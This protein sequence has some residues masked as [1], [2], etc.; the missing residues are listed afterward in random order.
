MKHKNLEILREHHINVPSF[1]VVDRK[2]ELDLS[3]SKE[4]L[5]AIRSSFEVEDDDESSFAGQF[6]TFLNVER[7]NVFSYVDKVKESYK[8]LNITNT[9]SKVIVQE[10]IQSDYSGVIFTANPTGILNEMVIVAGEGLGCNIVEDKIAA[11]TYYY[12]VDDKNYYFENETILNQTILNDLIKAAVKIKE[13]FQ[14]D[15]D[16]EYAVK[17]DNIYIL[18][19]RPI[20]TL[21][22]SKTIILDNSNI[23]ES[24]PGISLPLTQ[25]FAKQVYADVFKHCIYHL[26][27]KDKNLVN[28]MS[29]HLDNMLACTNGRIYYNINNWYLII[30]LLPCSEKLI[31]IWQEM[32]GVENKYVNDEKM[33]VTLLTKIKIVISFL[34]Y[35]QS[36]PK[37][38]KK[39]NRKFED[40]FMIF[41]E[42]VKAQ[43]SITDLLATYRAIEKAISSD[44]Y[45]TLINDMYTFIYTG[46]LSKKEKEKL[47]DIKNLE[48]MKPVV[49]L[50]TL[51]RVYKEEK[52]SNRFHQLFQEYIELYGDRCL[53]ELKLETQTYR[54]NPDLLLEYIQ[55]HDETCL[56]QSSTDI[57]V[58][59]K[60]K[61]AKLGIYNREISRL[62]RTRIF[63]L[64]R[65]IFLKIGEILVKE[66][67][68][69]KREDI[70]YLFLE[71]INEKDCYTELVNKRKIQYKKNETIP[72]YSRLVYA[73]QIVE[74]HF[75]NINMLNNHD[76]L[77]GTGSSLG[78]VEGEV[79]VVK[80]ADSNID[81]KNKIIVA[82][83]TDPGWVF[84]IKDAKGI[85]V[86]RGSILS[87]TAIITRELKKPSIVNVK[88]ATSLLKNGDYVQV[89]AYKGIVRRIDGA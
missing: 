16:I 36:T 74:K 10:M 66:E 82:E 83:S 9:A 61:K 39:L 11:T 69:E 62:N 85:I 33:P 26:S 56:D 28:S 80:D 79:V 71:E 21:K 24:Y 31:K 58:N 64:A 48:S 57:K 3:F 45:I 18:Q 37:S 70:F 35:L 40:D 27:Q 14:K 32:L 73:D 19:A 78:I 7:K 25:S 44:W 63:G 50:N 13:I 5:F 75:E 89:D 84:L 41:K 15:M 1:I 51:I 65:S 43:N 60:L 2:E 29:D 76:N 68:I 72:A 88:N 77:F 22:Y 47:N 54:V 4:E 86:E 52:K 81:V 55:N 6:E 59:R 67:R 23:V 38:M 53:G 34:Y 20:T 87:H 49:A 30:K 17:D 46:L 8:K 42:Q 12:N